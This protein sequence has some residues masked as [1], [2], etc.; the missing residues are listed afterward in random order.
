[1]QGNHGLQLLGQESEE[2][3]VRNLLDNLPPFLPEYVNIKRVNV[4]LLAASDNEASILE[5]GKNV[6][7]LVQ[8]SGTCNGEKT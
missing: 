7:G 2:C 8:A 1:M 3:F 5:R 6:C 4:G